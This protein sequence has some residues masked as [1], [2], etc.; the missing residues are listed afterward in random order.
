MKKIVT[1]LLAMLVFTSCSNNEAKEM[2]A[3]NNKTES[4]EIKTESKNNQTE[5]KSNQTERINYFDKENNIVYFRTVSLKINDS[6]VVKDQYMNEDLIKVGYEFNN[7]SAEDPVSLVDMVYQGQ[8][9]AYQENENSLIPLDFIQPSEL[10]ESDS[11][12]VKAK[13]GGKTEGSFYYALKNNE[14]PVTLKFLG[15]SGEIGT[16]KIDIK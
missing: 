14:D 8:I 9:E 6:I 13:K 10:E 1:F 3:Q 7:I 2:K 11:V 5:S 16:I 4:S 15:T 12:E